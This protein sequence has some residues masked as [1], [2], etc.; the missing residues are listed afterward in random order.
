MRT[1]R[2]AASL[3][4]AAAFGVVA[5]FVWTAST[6]GAPEPGPS[7]A[8]MVARGR[9]ARPADPVLSAEPAAAAS[10]AAPVRVVPGRS[11]VLTHL[12]ARDGA[13]AQI[14]RD[15]LAEHGA[16]LGVTSAP[17]S[18][19]LH[20]EITSLSGVHVRFRQT[21]DGVPVVG[22][23]VSA[24]VAPDGRP[25]L[26]RADLYPLHGIAG[27]QL[28]TLPWIDEAEARGAAASFVTD[29]ESD[30]PAPDIRT[31]RLAILP[32]GRDGRLVWIV[33]TVTP[34][35]SLRLYVDAVEGGVVRSENKRV[36]ADGVALIFDPNPVH[37]EGDSTL[38]DQSDRDYGAVT[39]ARQ[40]VTLRRLDGTGFLRGDWVDLRRSPVSTFSSELDW[41]FA[42]RS[43]HAFEQVMSYY[44]CD[45]V[46][47]RLRGLG[48]LNV[49]AERQDVN[50]HASS[51]DNSSY[52]TIDDVL[53]FG[54]GGVDDAEDADIIV[55][56][57]G[58]A[59]QHD[60]VD[61]YGRTGE[62]GAMGEGFSD[63]LAVLMHESG[64]PFWD[65]LFGSW[66][67]VGL[68]GAKDPP[69]LR[70]V[71]RDKVY[72]R[73]F[74]GQVH[75]DGE[76]W[77]RFLWDVR[78]AIG[79]D[80]ALQLV[81]EHHFFLGPNSRF[82][83][84]VDSLLAT[85]VALRDGRHDASLRAAASNRGLPFSVPPAPL[86]PEDA[87]DDNDVL[88]DAADLGVGDHPNLLLADDDWYRLVVP[89]FRRVLLRALF[90]PVSLDLDL[91]AH[92]PD[93]RPAGRS[94]GVSGVEE[95][96][97]AAGAAGVVV[98]VRCFRADGQTDPAAYDLTLVETDLPAFG[99]EQ[100]VVRTLEVGEGFAFRV[101]V[102]PQKVDDGSQMKLKSRRLSRGAKND[103]RVYRPN[104]TEVLGILE[105][106]KRRG[107][108][109]IV[110]PDEPGDW[111]VELV[112][113]D[114]TSGR[115]KLKVK[116]K[117]P[118]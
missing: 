39:N 2:L 8:E 92:T 49:N 75:G 74:V 89:P 96:E 19:T 12:P 67:A 27:E 41:S 108:K 112:P 36:A 84:A 109:A 114:D 43:H 76:I 18:L 28:A 72:P 70:R 17:G 52:D 57:Y 34:A 97:I 60:Q 91:R 45:R 26:L 79:A 31:P 68:P 62:G 37:S 10:V 58:H 71:D 56:E 55:H 48:I 14:A 11:L 59:M 61:D 7:L 101:P 77:S 63:F 100:T 64:R 103:L 83:D 38:R 16:A 113:R 4:S 102:E 106:R 24:H 73:D 69:A 32:E 87:F 25:L 40:L 44:H 98:H 46:Q 66:D 104:G 111:I 115:Y 81:V 90:D 29:E 82:R 33:D 99:P 13:P 80:A 15:L 47:E 93:G 117:T 42:T 86:P 88:G 9:I 35:E 107:A 116:F 53:K 6:P 54:D 105:T 21:V 110:T 20:R 94:D 51:A 30:A 3:A 95:L 85:N 50:A 65:P 23:E 22:S 118:R 5:C 78:Q 1:S